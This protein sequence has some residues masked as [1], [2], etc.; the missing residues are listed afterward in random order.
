MKLIK[1][2]ETMQKDSEWKR[3]S[4]TVSNQCKGLKR[5]WIKTKEKWSNFC[6]KKDNTNRKEIMNQCEGTKRTINQ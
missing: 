1:K 2:Q 4:K 3:L 6:K 5:K